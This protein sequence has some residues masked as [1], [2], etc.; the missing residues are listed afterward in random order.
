MIFK[1]N[2]YMKYSIVLMVTGLALAAGGCEKKSVY[3]PPYQDPT[4]LNIA[5]SG[6]D[7]GDTVVT[8]GSQVSYGTYSLQSTST[9]TW[10][11]PADATVISGAGTNAITIQF[12]LASGNVS[13]SAGSLSGSVASDV[14]FSV[15][16]SSSVSSGGTATY[17]TTPVM[18]SG[19]T[20]QWQVP[21]GATIVSGSGTN[22]V[23][24]LF[25]TP[26]SVQ[27]SCTA[28]D[29]QATQSSSVTVT[30]N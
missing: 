11:V 24:V 12:G 16:G 6:A 10:Q 30:V 25:T 20:Y 26:G 27:V 22:Q 13:V 7:T 4:F 5:I 21:S 28:S 23:Q 17:T 9:Y 29:S 15:F 14:Q 19:V 1:M 18:L 8:A 3:D 2:Y